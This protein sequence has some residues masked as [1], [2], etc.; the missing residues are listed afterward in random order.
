MLSLKTIE[1]SIASIFVK[2]GLEPDPDDNRRVLAVLAY[3]DPG[4]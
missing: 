4:R 2:P 1:G 3:L